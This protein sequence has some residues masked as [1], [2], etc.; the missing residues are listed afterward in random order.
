MKQKDDINIFSCTNI[1]NLYIIYRLHNIKNDNK[2]FQNRGNCKTNRS[3]NSFNNRHYYYDN[4]SNNNILNLKRTDLPIKITY[5]YILKY[6]D[7][8]QPTYIERNIYL[9]GYISFEF[10][11]YDN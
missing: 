3:H 11:Y 8:N 6:N 10:E 2:F 7:F 5:D 1:C 9:G 4:I